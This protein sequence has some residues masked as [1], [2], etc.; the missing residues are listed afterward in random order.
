MV[1]IMEQE[2][3]KTIYCWGCEMPRTNIEKQMQVVI[4]KEL[5]NLKAQGMLHITGQNIS[6]TAKGADYVEVSNIVP[7]QTVQQ[8]QV[9]RSFVKKALR[10]VLEHDVTGYNVAMQEARKSFPPRFVTSIEKFYW[11]NLP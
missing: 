2:I 9:A 11:N 3:L 7:L 10:S 5:N 1:G 6:L 4:T 8:V